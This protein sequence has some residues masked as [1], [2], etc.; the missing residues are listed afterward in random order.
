MINVGLI[1]YRGLNKS[2]VVNGH[3]IFRIMRMLL[4]EWVMIIAFSFI[5]FL[6]LVSAADS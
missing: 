4:W 3:D 5:G 2:C 6:V 1:A